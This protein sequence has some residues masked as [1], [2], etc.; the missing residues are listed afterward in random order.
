MDGGGFLEGYGVEA[1][2]S[3]QKID[4]IQYRVKRAVSH[5]HKRA[6]TSCNVQGADD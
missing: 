4:C 5:D 1:I 2:Y 3:V 6:W